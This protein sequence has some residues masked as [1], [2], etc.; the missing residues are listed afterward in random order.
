[1]RFKSLLRFVNAE[2]YLRGESV[3]NGLGMALNEMFDILYMIDI[4]YY[5][6]LYDIGKLGD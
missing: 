4:Q 1:M 3:L 5:T 6:S 2:Y